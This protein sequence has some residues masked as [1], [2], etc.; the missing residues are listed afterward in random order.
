M[1]CLF[2]SKIIKNMEIRMKKGVII[3]IVVVLLIAL[4]IMWGISKYNRFV[5]E[6][7]TVEVA[8]GQVQ[9]IYQQRFDMIPNLVN[10]VKGARDFEQETLIA[11]TEARSKMG[12]KIEISP[13][14]L[15]DPNAFAQ[16]QSMQDNLSSALQRLMVVV[17]RYPELKSNQNFLQLQ[18]QYEGIEN[19]VKTE[20]MRYN[21][22]V[23]TFNKLIVTFPNNMLAR[24]FNIKTFELFKAAEAAEAAPTIA[25]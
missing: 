25:F 18:D 8:W 17:E 11:V 16:F 10:I 7:T 4:P 21:E 3:L 6:R 24:M 9:N 2:W 19:R 20:R 15:S 12:G 23:G 5:V 1:L 22:A 13:E 14:T